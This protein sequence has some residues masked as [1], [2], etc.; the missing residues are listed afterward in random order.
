MRKPVFEIDGW[1]LDD[2]EQINRE[3]PQ[4]FL[5]PDLAG[6]KILQPGDYAKLIFRIAVEGDDPVAVERMWVI[7]RELIPGGYMGMLD[8]EPDAISENSSF[9]CGVELPFEYRHIIAV[10]HATAESRA[11]ASLPPPIFWD[12]G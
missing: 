9:W 4:T 5:I 12:R 2:G 1:C 3:F 6:R 7:V 11:L 10:E 8:N